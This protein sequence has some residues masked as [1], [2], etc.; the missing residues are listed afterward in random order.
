M[1]V[2]Q[3]TVLQAQVLRVISR[4]VQLAIDGCRRIYSNWEE[5]PQEAQHVLVNMCFQMGP[6]GLSKFKHMNQAVR[7]GLGASSFR[8]G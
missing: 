3:K 6:T 8:D 1:I 4:N 2:R 5:L 7:I